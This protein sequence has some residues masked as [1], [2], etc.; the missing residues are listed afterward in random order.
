M[1]GGA[2]EILGLMIKL[3]LL[4]V[5]GGRKAKVYTK[6]FKV[7]DQVFEYVKLSID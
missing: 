3:F 7:L 6:L 5:A 4:A 1:G 2:G